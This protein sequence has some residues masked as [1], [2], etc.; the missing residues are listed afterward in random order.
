[1]N[2]E[3]WAK[4]LCLDSCIEN[5][6]YEK[7][8]VYKFSS[9][10]LKLHNETIDINNFIGVIVEGSK[11]GNI[12][13]EYSKKNNNI[14]EGDLIELQSQEKKI[15][16]QIVGGLTEYEKLE[17][18]NESGFIIGDAIQLGIWNEISSSF[19]KFG[20]IPEINTPIF[21][22]ETIDYQ[23][24]EIT[25]PE[26]KLGNIPNTFLPSIINLE[27]A[28]S[29]HTALLGITG[30]GKSFLAR[31][32]INSLNDCGTKVICIDFTGEWKKSM[33]LQSLNRENLDEF[34]NPENNQI[35]LVELPSM[36]NTVA[37]IEST[38]SFI[39]TIFNKAK[40]AYESGNPMKICLVLE[41]AHTII[42]EANFLGVNDFNSKAVV[43]KM[44]QVALQGRKYGVGLFV[45]AQRTANVSKTVLT[46][47]NTI[48]C[49]QAFDETSFTFLGNYIGKDLVQALPNLKK[50][51]AIVTGKA[52][53][54]NI[55]MIVDLERK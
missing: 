9:N 48:I 23:V 34:L 51:H 1:M 8:I 37:V 6:K 26:F 32:I 36:S 54:S 11:I 39:S 46:Q 52:S 15:F 55:P 5:K 13:F 41:E 35:G 24:K 43:N 20:W 14:Q 29:H 7:N 30:S 50:Y 12:R 42:P 33:D 49:F 31:E 4:I 18:K 21:L 28:V 16:Y 10:D 40:E 38:E 3:K 53:K 27:E 19:E 17:N 44:G 2:S 45:I 47:C 25:H 22:A